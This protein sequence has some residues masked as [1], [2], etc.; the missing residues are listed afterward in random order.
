MLWNNEVFYKLVIGGAT[1]KHIATE[2][3]LVTPGSNGPDLV[4]NAPITYRA[5]NTSFLLSFI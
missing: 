3:G 5:R 1:K 2:M 4:N